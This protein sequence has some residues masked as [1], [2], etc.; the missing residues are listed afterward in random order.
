MADAHSLLYKAGTYGLEHLGL[1]SAAPQWFCV[2]RGWT[3][4][5]KAMPRRRTGVNKAEAISAW[6]AHVRSEKK[7]VVDG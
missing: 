7:G 5:A 3:F 1:R 2:C 4:P 6:H